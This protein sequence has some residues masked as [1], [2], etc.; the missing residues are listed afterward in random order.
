MPSEEYSPVLTLLRPVLTLLNP[1][2]VEVEQAGYVAVGRA[3]AS[4]QAGDTPCS[5]C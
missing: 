4:A 1:V 5:N 3:Q 2:E